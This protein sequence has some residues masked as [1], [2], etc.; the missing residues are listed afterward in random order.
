MGIFELYPSG[1]PFKIGYKF[2]ILNWS[3]PPLSPYT[4]VFEE[5][6]DTLSA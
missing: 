4:Q 2:K 1:G 6:V 5:D 3:D